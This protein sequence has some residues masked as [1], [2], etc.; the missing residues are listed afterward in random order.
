MEKMVAKE[1]DSWAGERPILKLR[2][3]IRNKSVDIGFS[4]WSRWKRVGFAPTL[5]VVE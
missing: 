5:F 2:I 1:V 4:A 3:S